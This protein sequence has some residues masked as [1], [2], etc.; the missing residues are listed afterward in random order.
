MSTSSSK[1]FM[2][3]ECVAMAENV[4][5]MVIPPARK[6]TLEDGASFGTNKD[7][8]SAAGFLAA[9]PVDLAE[10]P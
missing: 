2:L 8:L 5:S 3:Y 4:D 9:E 1:M 7:N 10:P 6:T